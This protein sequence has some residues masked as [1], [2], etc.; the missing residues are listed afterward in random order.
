VHFVGHNLGRED[1][2]NAEAVHF[3]GHNLGREDLNNA[4]AAEVAR[5]H[6]ESPEAAVVKVEVKVASLEKLRTSTSPK[7]CT[8]SFLRWGQHEDTKLER[9]LP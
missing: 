8:T 7:V 1:L 6:L 4:E 9:L 5:R 2:N 3:V